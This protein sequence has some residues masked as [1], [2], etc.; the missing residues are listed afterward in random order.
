MPYISLPNL[1]KMLANRL[2]ARTHR[3][4]QSALQTKYAYHFIKN[5]STKPKVYVTRAV[6]Q[7]ALDILQET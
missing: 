4:V 3:L 7:E 6:N 5:M 1:Q 2:A